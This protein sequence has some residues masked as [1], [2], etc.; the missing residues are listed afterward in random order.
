MAFFLP[1]AA[2]GRTPRQRTLTVRAR[3][4]LGERPA[5][6]RAKRRAEPT[7]LELWTEYRKRHRKA[8]RTMVEDGRRW[9]RHL[10]GWASR[11]A[12][13]IPK[14]DVARLLHRVA[15]NSG[16]VESNR[17]RSMLHHLYSWARN[18]ELI[19]CENPA[20]GLRGEPEAP[21]ERRFSDDEIRRLLAAIADESDPLWQGYFLLLM[22][23][24]CR[25]GELLAARWEWVQLEHH[26]PMLVLPRGTTKQRREHCVPLSSEAV[27]VLEQ[28]PS[29]RTSQFFFPSPNGGFRR[30]PKRAWAAVRDRA[31]LADVHLHDVR[32]L[33]GQ[34]LAEAGSSSFVI[35]RTLGHS[36]IATSARYV[37]LALEMAHLALAGC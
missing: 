11:I 32:H 13:T 31:G 15:E 37:D 35:Q 21:R 29:R 18:V 36:K 2:T 24:G 5:D 17:L 12:S 30:E 19:G 3:L 33:L 16:P 10:T 4:D 26:P 9:Q 34:S 1:V 6:E 8:D 22:L 25:R 20:A 7:L 28:L 14:R 27:Q 23:T